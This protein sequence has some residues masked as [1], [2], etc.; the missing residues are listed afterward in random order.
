MKNKILLLLL[1]LN[2]SWLLPVDSEDITDN[3]EVINGQNESNDSNIEPTDSDDD[4][5]G[6]Q[7]QGSSDKLLPKRVTFDL[8]EG[9]QRDSEA[10]EDEANR[11]AED[12]IR[13]TGP[14]AEDDTS[15]EENVADSAFG[16]GQNKSTKPSLTL[17]QIRQKNELRKERLMN[18]KEADKFLE[19]TFKSEME[20]KSIKDI[21]EQ[22]KSLEDEYRGVND[23]LDLLEKQKETIAGLPTSDANRKDAPQ[24]LKVIKDSQQQYYNKRNDISLK[25]DA[26][27]EIIDEKIEQVSNSLSQVNGELESFIGQAKGTRTQ[28]DYNRLNDSINATYTSAADT[29]EAIQELTESLGYKEVKKR[30]WFGRTK[31]VADY[32]DVSENYMSLVKDLLGQK[33]ELLAVQDKATTAMRKLEDVDPTNSRFIRRLRM[34]MRYG[35]LQPSNSLPDDSI[36]SGSQQTEPLIPTGSKNYLPGSAPNNAFKAG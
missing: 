14:S 18:L 30:G 28:L 26:V 20:Q 33:Q 2:F 36:S 3:Q 24:E 32:S 17:E 7:D 4:G 23:K 11:G 35:D 12:S 27:D 6:S 13:D 16:L 22:K 25:I 31:I 8:P 5:Y 10:L 19:S 15:A 29:I 9:S 1:S 21:F 34:R